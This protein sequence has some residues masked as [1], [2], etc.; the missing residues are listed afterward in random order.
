[1]KLPRA[2]SLTWWV[3][4]LA[5]LGLSI[6][7][8]RLAG[9][10][11]F[12][13]AGTWLMT[14]N[15]ATAFFAINF[16]F[17]GYNLS[18]YN[19][20]WRRLSG[21]HWTIF[22]CLLLLP[23]L[24]ALSFL[25]LPGSL[26]HAALVVAPW[27]AFLAIHAYLLTAEVLDPVRVLS[28]EYTDNAIESYRERLANVVE[29]DWK[30]QDAQKLVP[31]GKLPMHMMSHRPMVIETTTGGMWDR[32]M[33]VL[34]VAVDMHDFAV[35]SVSF[36]KCFEILKSLVSERK[37]LDARTLSGLRDI[38]SRRMQS[39]LMTIGKSSSDRVFMEAANN[40][41]CVELT[42]TECLTNFR[43]K[44]P[45]H[46]FQM[47]EFI[48]KETLVGGKSYDAVKGLNA[49]HA[50][51]N[52]T[53]KHV[54]EMSAEERERLGPQVTFLDLPLVA[55]CVSAI[56]VLGQYAIRGGD[57]EFLYRCLESLDW[58]GC[59]MAKHK[60]QE[61]LLACMAGLVQLGREAR[62]KKLQCFWE[63]CLVPPHVHAQEKLGDI[64]TWLVQHKTEEGFWC[65]GEIMRALSRLR[66]YWCC[67]EPDP[68]S[69]VAFWIK[70]R[71]DENGNRE[72]CRIEAMSATGHSSNIDYSDPTELKEYQLY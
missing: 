26:W 37:G 20:L 33:T 42:S 40:R 19:K 21:M 27:V 30:R 1:M 49:I 11:D 10:T 16:A 63:P 62:H 31:L 24:P 17:I 60:M 2:E 72:P 8:F 44:F 64:L 23:L 57:V 66:G 65:D 39:V 59:E 5:A 6:L 15:F 61:P 69:S 41:L 35:F 48:G 50:F 18:P 28:A 46:L 58:L 36:D 34:S 13:E 3:G 22:S 9:R 51:T 25:V 32:L 45:K 54:R 52:A 38:A 4:A 70:D 43:G 67:I 29:E 53:A 12:K 68:E 7:F 71:T 47:I 55:N 56:K 14:A